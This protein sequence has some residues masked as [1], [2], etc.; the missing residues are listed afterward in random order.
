[1]TELRKNADLILGATALLV[2]VGGD[3]METLNEVHH[4]GIVQGTIRGPA[5]V[6]FIILICLCFVFSAERHSQ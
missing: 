4:W 1:M 5:F 2:I 3:Y 6:L